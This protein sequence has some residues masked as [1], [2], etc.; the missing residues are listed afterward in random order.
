MVL[1]VT[2]SPFL[3][4]ATLRHHIQQYSKSLTPQDNK[5]ATSEEDLSFAKASL[6][7]KREDGEK[8][9]Q[10]ILGVKWSCREDTLSLELEKQLQGKTPT[11][12]EVV[13]AAAKVFGMAAPVTV[14]WKM[15]FQEVC[16]SGTSH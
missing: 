11:K 9:E 8:G 2:C 16:K 12:R 1:G 14:L 6:G 7:V 4:N 3:L 10:K 13:A 15:L 5:A